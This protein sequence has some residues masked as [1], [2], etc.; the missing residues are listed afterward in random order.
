M[1]QISYMLGLICQSEARVRRLPFGLEMRSA[2]VQVAMVESTGTAAEVFRRRAASCRDLAETA[3]TPE[4]KHIL[5]QLASD[6]E[7][8]ARAEELENST[9]RRPAFRWHVG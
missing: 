6:Y 2:T 3:V 7:T 9:R 4:A 8:R 1:F 5:G